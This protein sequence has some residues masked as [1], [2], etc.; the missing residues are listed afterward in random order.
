MKVKARDIIPGWPKGRSTWAYTP[1][2]WDTEWAKV[3]CMQPEAMV[4]L[5]ENVKYHEQQQKMVN[6]FLERKLDESLWEC[7]LWRYSVI[8]IDRRSRG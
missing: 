8:P 3:Y 7:P 1:S 6:T 2:R 5:R 4:E